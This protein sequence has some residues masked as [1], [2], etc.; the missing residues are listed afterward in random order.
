MKSLR[1]KKLFLLTFQEPWLRMVL[2]EEMCE[3][4]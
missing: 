2:E 1:A 4:I 3:P